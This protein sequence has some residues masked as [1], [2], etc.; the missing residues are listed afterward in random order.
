MF[1]DLTMVG[2]DA[3]N[4]LYCICFGK[5]SKDASAW[6]QNKLAMHYKFLIKPEE[7]CNKYPRYSEK[8]L[9]NDDY[10]LENCIK[11]FKAK[12]NL[13]SY[14]IPYP[15]IIVRNNFINLIEND[16]YLMVP[17]REI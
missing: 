17:W 4:I 11:I 5:M 9:K 6:F 2:L 8:F 14:T 13:I 12:M 15:I 3:E 7:I 16:D 10:N 1:R